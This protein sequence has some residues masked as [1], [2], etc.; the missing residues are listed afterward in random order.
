METQDFR[1]GWLVKITGHR[2]KSLNGAVGKVEEIKKHVIS[3]LFEYSDGTYEIAQCMA[4]EL[5]ICD[6]NGW[7]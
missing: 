4:H 1:K 5:I 6:K 2:N 3:V 7:A